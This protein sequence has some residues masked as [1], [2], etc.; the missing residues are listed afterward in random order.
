MRGNRSRA[1]HGGALGRMAALAVLRELVEGALAAGARPASPGEFTY[2]ALR[3]GRLDL[4]SAEAVRD[5]IAARTL[6]QARIAHAQSEG[7]L[8]RR[9]APVREALAEL[10]ARVEAAVEFVDEAEVEVSEPAAARRDRERRPG[11]SEHC[12][13]AFAP[14]GWCVRARWWR[15]PVL[16]TSAS[17]RCSTRCWRANGR[18]FP[19]SRA[20]HG[21]RS[22]KLDLEGLPVTADRHGGTARNGRSDRAR[23]RARGA[24][25]AAREADLV[26]LVL[27]TGR[28]LHEDR[29]AR[30]RAARPESSLLV[31]NKADLAPVGADV[32]RRARYSAERNHGRGIDAL[33]KAIRERLVGAVQVDDRY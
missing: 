16:R 21:T 15:S 23:R 20:P 7:A 6:S 11:S 19:R 13:P 29:E 14:A 27:E 28:E 2:R 32:A 26:V 5:L 18:S 17:H 33:R 12:S 9:L 3:N 30:D 31:R 1:S 10:V 22:R 8:S 4:A 24:G 25:T